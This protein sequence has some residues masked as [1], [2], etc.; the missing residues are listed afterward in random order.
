MSSFLTI[1]TKHVTPALD[2]MLLGA[3]A[4]G[5]TTGYITPQDILSLL[6]LSGYSLASHNHDDLY[7]SIDLLTQI[8]A[9]LQETASSLEALSELSEQTD[10]ILSDQIADNSALISSVTQ[11]LSS[12][13]HDGAYANIAHSHVHYFAYSGSDTGRTIN[14]NSTPLAFIGVCTNG[15]LFFWVNPMAGAWIFSFGSSGYSSCL[16]A[17]GSTYVDVP[18]EMDVSGNSYRYMCLGNG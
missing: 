17:I 11:Q 3:V 18:A 12:H 10:F 7:A 5:L 6:D 15:T 1:K 13:N 9:T 16:V 4:S 8:N 14:F 2:N